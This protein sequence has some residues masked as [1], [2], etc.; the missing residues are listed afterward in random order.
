MTIAVDTFITL[1]TQH[2]RGPFSDWEYTPPRKR[3]PSA[4]A[5]D[6][7]ATEFEDILKEALSASLPTGEDIP[8]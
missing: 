5:G 7:E 2:P 1:T 8:T 6:R 4:N 3:T